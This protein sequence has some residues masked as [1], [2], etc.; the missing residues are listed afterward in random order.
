MTEKIRD[1]PAL[2][3]STRHWQQT[4]ALL[5]TAL[6]IAFPVYKAVESGRRSDALDAQNSALVTQGQ[7]LWGTNCSSCHGV[8][9]EGVSAPALNSQQFLQNVSD[10]QMQDIIAGGIPGTAMPAW[11]NEYGG[12][13]TA[14]QIEALTTYLRS[15][16][17]D[18]PSVPD[19]RTPSG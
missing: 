12:P 19:W 7:N 18:A 9:G 5:L 16:Q 3:R 10:K 13:L 17:K 4:G 1:D 8:N 11:W 6:V 14:Q 15:K 2:A